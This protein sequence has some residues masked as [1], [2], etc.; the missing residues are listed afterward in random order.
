M[1]VPMV[2]DPEVRIRL[3]AV[4]AI[5]DWDDGS[6]ETR[7]RHDKELALKYGRLTPEESLEKYMED[8]EER[9][10]KKVENIRPIDKTKPVINPWQK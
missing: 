7:E 4:G 9:A 8:S 6:P 3:V 1:T 10:R 5:S 2:I